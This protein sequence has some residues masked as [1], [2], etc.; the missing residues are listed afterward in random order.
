MTPRILDIFLPKQAGGNLRILH[1]LFQWF[2][3]FNETVSCFKSLPLDLSY[4]CLVVTVTEWFSTLLLQFKT[5][6]L[7]PN[8]KVFHDIQWYFSCNHITLSCQYIVLYFCEKLGFEVLCSIRKTEN[9]QLQYIKEAFIITILTFGMLYT[10]TVSFI[11]IVSRWDG[12]S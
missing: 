9:L 10:P 12:N 7:Y 1:F 2:K 11:T 6:I 4:S 5:G 8:T 3:T